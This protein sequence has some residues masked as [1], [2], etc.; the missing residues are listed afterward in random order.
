MSILFRLLLLIGAIAVFAFILKKIR[1][2]EIKIADA[3]FWFV[4]GASIVL[5]SIFPQIAY[6]FCDIFDI[7][8]PIHFVYLVIIGVLLVR[9]FTVNVE[10]AKLR[11]KVTTLV[12]NEALARHEAKHENRD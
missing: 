12:Q 4:F 7:D 5:L 9:L 8:S 2:S 11:T 1:K 3:T 10:L 6:F